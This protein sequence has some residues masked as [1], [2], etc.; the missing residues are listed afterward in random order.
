MSWLEPLL[1][2]DCGGGKNKNA[3]S[4]WYSQA[5]THPSTNQARR[6]LASEIRRDRARSAWCGRKRKLPSQSVAS[7][8]SSA[9]YCCCDAGAFFFFCFVQHCGA[10]AHVWSLGF[11]PELGTGQGHSVRPGSRCGSRP[12]AQGLKMV[13]KDPPPA[14]SFTWALA[15]ISC[16]SS[17]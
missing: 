14:P 5:V 8:L 4:T 3:Y 10:E 7:W 6:C 17:V 2:L 9:F 12:E 15:H 1:P 13:E 11:W 16:G